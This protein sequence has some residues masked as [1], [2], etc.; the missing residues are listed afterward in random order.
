MQLK[1]QQ[2]TKEKEL[3]ELL[4]SHH[5]SMMASYNKAQSLKN[6]ILSSKEVLDSYSRLFVAGKKQ[7]L[8]LVNASRELMQNNQELASQE[9]MVKVLK[10][11]LALTIGDIDLENGELKND[12]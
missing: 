11:K 1:F 12:L 9:A 2:L 8:D 5:N 6:T 4:V 3:I 7:W 10:Y